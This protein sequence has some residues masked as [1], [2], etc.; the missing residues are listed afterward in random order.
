MQAWTNHNSENFCCSKI[1][2]ARP[3]TKFKPASIYLQDTFQLFNFCGLL[4]PTKYFN[5]KLHKFCSQFKATNSRIKLVYNREQDCSGT[6]GEWGQT[7]LFIYLDYVIDWVLYFLEYRLGP[8]SFRGVL[9]PASVQG[10]PQ[11]MAWL[12]LFLF[13]WRE[14]RTPGMSPSPNTVPHTSHCGFA[15]SDVPSIS[16]VGAETTPNTFSDKSCPYMSNSTTSSLPKSTC[17]S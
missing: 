6:I 11:I 10:W 5:T 7:S 13:Q 17:N 3:T 14:E 1:L 15:I 12:W 2:W 8:V 16:S 9:P 4:W